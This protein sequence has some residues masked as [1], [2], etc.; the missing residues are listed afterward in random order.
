MNCEMNMW[1][2]HIYFMI[3]GQCFQV[4]SVP[5][6]GKAMTKNY[7]IVGSDSKNLVSIVYIT[8]E[9]LTNAEHTDTIFKDSVAAVI[10]F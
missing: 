9:P 5:L 2:E 6:F 7:F 4:G 3:L 1:N 8:N 10:I